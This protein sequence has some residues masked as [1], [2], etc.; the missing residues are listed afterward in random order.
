MDIMVI[1]LICMFGTPAEDCTLGSDKVKVVIEG[2]MVDTVKE[3]VLAAEQI[4]ARLTVPV[5]ARLICRWQ[6]TA[7]KDQNIIN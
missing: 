1:L 6:R 3:C 2:P 7:P 4:M 5:G